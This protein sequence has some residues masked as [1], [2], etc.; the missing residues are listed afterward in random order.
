MRKNIIIGIAVLAFSILAC[1]TSSNPLKLLARATETPEYIPAVPVVEPSAT[2][3]PTPTPLPIIRLHD[4]DDLMFRGDY[5]QAIAQ[6]QGAFAQAQDD[7]TRAAALYGEGLTHFKNDNFTQASTVLGNLVT[8]FS[9]SPRAAMGEFLLGE[10]SAALEQPAEA[11]LHF[12]KYQNRRPGILDDYVQEKLGDELA[13]EG[14]FIEAINAYLAAEASPG[15]VTN[16][17]TIDLKI[18]K[19]LRSSGDNPGTIRQLQT[20]YDNPASNEYDKAQANLILGQIYLEMNEPEQAYARFQDSVNNFPRAFDSFTAL[21]ALVDANQTV[22]ELQRGTIDYNMQKYALAVDAFNRYIKSSEQVEPSAYYLKALSLREM[23]QYEDA[24]A[25]FDTLIQKYAGTEYY[26][27]AWNEKAYTQWAYLDRYQEAAETMLS[28]VRLYP[29]DSNA[30]DFLFEAARIFERGEMYQ[31]AIETWE[32]IINEYPNYSQSYRALFL[33]GITRYRVND[34]TGAQNTFQRSLVLATTPSDQAASSFWT[35]KSQLMQNDS[36]AARVSWQTATQ[37]DP[38]GYYS[39]RAKLLLTEQ[40]P[41]TASPSYDLG[42][43]LAGER[44]EAEN[45]LI[46]TFNLAEDSD[47]SSPGQ[48]S[49]DLHFQRAREYHELGLYSEASREMTILTTANE[50]DPV[51]LFKLLDPL[52]EMGLYRS[53]IV[54]SRQI[55]DLAK[56]DD[57]ATLK[58]PVFFNHI[59]FGA[60][61]RE[62]VLQAAQNENIHP[63]VLFSVLRQESMFEG[64]VESSAGARGIMQIMPATGQEIS[65]GMG[66]PQN[67]KADDLYRPMISIRLGAR[68]LARQRDYFG[69]DLMAALA[70]YNAGPGNAEIWLN[71]ANKDTD[72]F[73]EIIRYEETRR[74]LTQISE[75][76]AIYSRLYERMP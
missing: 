69:G 68:Y 13:L 26:L 28:F 51:Q 36:T 23:Q 38:T 32:R 43:D 33:S 24:T 6:Y 9:D 53:A 45:W 62:E 16:P 52:L 5:D 65:G 30:P 3:V 27:K 4:A 17:I 64:F 76:T 11:V 70:G 66:W 15:L 54:T 10:I 48:I 59:R 56:L 44:K 63:F 37:L 25:I 50:S 73:L 12:T 35:G 1:T 22:N 29:A 72:L 74:Y 60:Y 40:Q 19:A 41:L 2:P 61:F 58:A 42:Y 46:K 8:N 18:A 14:N 21:S 71:L 7:E 55:L 20:I 75:F 39:E 31:L 47:L 49:A 67:Y 34:F 57:A